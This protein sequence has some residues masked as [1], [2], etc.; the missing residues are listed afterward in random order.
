[1]QRGPRRIRKR[2]IRRQIVTENHR[3]YARAQES[4]SREARVNL[5]I[6]NLRQSE[7]QQPRFERLIRIALTQLGGRCRLDDRAAVNQQRRVALHAALDWIAG[8]HPAS[9]DEQ[10]RHYGT[11][12]YAE[13]STG[14][15]RRS[16]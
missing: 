3:R 12:R 13:Y 1:M 2:R 4:L 15:P 9:G 10:P 16:Y 7:T 6:R 14:Y 8:E 5:W 11:S